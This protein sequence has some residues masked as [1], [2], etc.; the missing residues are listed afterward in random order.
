VVCVSRSCCFAA[1][2]AVALAGCAW[3]ARSSVVPNQT[4]EAGDGPSSD[5]S[6]S[7]GGRWVAF[8]SGAADLVPGDTNGVTD[9]FVRDHVAKTTE[10]VSVA[11]GGAEA[12]GPSR[13]PAISDDGRF[14]AFETGAVNL[15]PDGLPGFTD[16][17]VRDRLRGTTTLVSADLIGLPVAGGP[18]AAIA[19]VISGDGGTVAFDLRV[20]GDNEACCTEVGPYVRDLGAA[21]TTP[22]FGVTLTRSRGGMDLSDDGSLIA[23]GEVGTGIRGETPYAVVVATTAPP[24]PATVVGFGQLSGRSSETFAVALAGDGG[25]AIFR[26]G[27]RLS[28]YTVEDGLLETRDRFDLAQVQPI[29]GGLDASDDGSVLGMAG[30]D[31]LYVVT[32]FAGSVPPRLASADP[33]GRRV[34]VFGSDLSGDGRFVAFATADPDVLPGDANGVSD[35]YLRSATGVGGPS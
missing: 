14:V 16:I 24:A 6:V 3:T 2:L 32:D 1:A 25:A 28:R 4:F 12:D 10:R 30:L 7:Q 23:Y 9:V 22:M 5:P 26:V 13:A 11:T 20:D 19:P 21:T 17:V 34:S 18:V 35:V 31:G 33:R 8:A 15:A 27:A 29:A